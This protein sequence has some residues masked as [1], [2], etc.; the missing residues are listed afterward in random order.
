MLELDGGDAGGQFLRTALTLSVV[1]ATPVRLT[2]VRGDRPEP[3][4]KPQHA[5]VVETLATLC[6]A[7]VSGDA[8]GSTTVEF[9][10][11]RFEPRHLDVAVGT[12]G[13]LALLFDAVLPLAART[14]APFSVSASGGTDVAWSPPLSY[15]EHVKLPLLR[16]HGVQAAVER[17]RT[18]FY[19]AGGGRA[20]LHVAPSAPTPLDLTARGDGRGV[21]V[22]SRCSEGLRDADVANR[23][24]AAACERVED[25][26]LTVRHETTTVA[27]TESPGSTVTVCL[28]Y[29]ETRA[30]FCALGERGLPA[31]DMGEQAATDALAFHKGTAAV[32]RHMADQLLVFAAVAGGDFLAPAV[33]DHV[34]TSVALLAA[35]GVDAT[36]STDAT[37][38]RVSVADPLSSV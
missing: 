17:D 6:D 35:F 3:G 37:T 9:D 15:F 10:P 2:E 25:A 30:G 31:E 16:R 8:R 22:H 5:T 20:T 27:D 13:S 24:A 19:P 28:D 1:T 34:E 7:D 21:A 14:D 4:L 29:A 32:D 12:A 18:G 36:V 26:G 33:T 23:Q 11:G 38:A